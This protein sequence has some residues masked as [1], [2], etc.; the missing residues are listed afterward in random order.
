MKTIDFK[1]GENVSYDAKMAGEIVTAL[2]ETSAN[3]FIIAGNAR[4]NAKSIIGVISLAL[5]PGDEISVQSQGNGEEEAVQI[6]KN[7]LG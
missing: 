7:L 3:V 1:V 4:V 6:V 5:K 2:S